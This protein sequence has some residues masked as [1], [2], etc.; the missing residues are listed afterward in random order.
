MRVAVHVCTTLAFVVM[1]PM[2]VSAQV[3]IDEVLWAGSDT[4]SSDEWIELLNASTNEV[5]LSGWKVQ[6]LNSAGLFATFFTFEQG[7]VLNAGE[8]CIV[9]H[10]SASASRLVDEP[11][12]IAPSITLSNT[13]LLLKLVDAEGVVID[14]VGDGTSPFAGANPTNG[15]D[16]KASM[17]RIDFFSSGTNRSNWRTA[18]LSIGFDAG[19]LVR[20][21]PGVSSDVNPQSSGSSSSSSLIS[22]ASS[23]SSVS[24]SSSSPSLSSSATSSSTES[25]SI[26]S[27]ETTLCVDEF[28]PEIVVQSGEL[29]G[30]GSTT[31]NLQVIAAEGVLHS[32][33]VCS[34]NYGDGYT[35]DSCNP[36]PHAFKQVGL[37]PVTARVR[38]ACSE[39][40][41]TSIVVEVL[42][43]GTSVQSSS[44]SNTLYDSSPLYFS[45]AMPNPEGADTGH[46]WVEIR[47]PNDRSVSLEGWSLSIGLNVRKVYKLTGSI[48]PHSIQRVQSIESVFQLTNSEGKVRL[49]DSLAN[50][51]SILYWKNAPENQIIFPRDVLEHQIY[52]R[53]SAVINT[54]TVTLIPEGIAASIFDLQ[55]IPIRFIGLDALDVY[56]PIPSVRTLAQKRLDFL[57]HTLQ[58]QRVSL[59]FDGDALWDADGTLLA[60]VSPIDGRD[61]GQQLLSLGLSTIQLGSVFRLRP[62]YDEAQEW[63]RSRLLG[64]WNSGVQREIVVLQQNT[65][66]SSL[67][68][69][70]LSIIDVQKVR[71]KILITEVYP[72]PEKIDEVDQGAL[73]TNEKNI[74]EKEWIELQNLLPYPLSL[75][76]WILRVGKKSKVLSDIQLTTSSGF[77]LLF[78]DQYKLPLANDGTSIALLTPTGEVVASTQ[79]SAIK[80]GLS[81]VYDSVHQTSCV[82]RTFT[83][84]HAADC[85]FDVYQEPTKDE[86]SAKRSIAAKKAA[87]TKA[88]KTLARNV[89]LYERQLKDFGSDVPQI[90]F[91]PASQSF[92]WSEMMLGLLVGSGSSA[93]FMYAWIMGSVMKKREHVKIFEQN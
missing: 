20:G 71:D 17:E 28:V 27:S 42:P 26:T 31:L 60:H 86:I 64:V 59:E 80:R 12:W 82:S 44:T 73:S 67:S 7:S 47:N 8:H 77:T 88:A 72:Y 54:T 70:N 10:Y 76:G 22:S 90:I 43:D 24:S 58:D 41:E 68:S 74:V 18:I 65:G 85:T 32:S 91:A 14:T 40:K 9:A 51:R 81:L 92:G 75:S 78:L 61:T 53:V 2:C 89:E 56:S 87:A 49:I 25:S 13:K 50:E 30:V 45:G 5:D 23:V 39:H 66:S 57:K 4:S 36:P 35:S 19:A 62:V 79:Y 11:C 15:I 55:P 37:F 46:E 33:Y 93:G 16:P 52:G 63:A 69:K 1:F 34:W 3:V 21:T 29:R 48:S 83:P 6:Y 84:L 38:N